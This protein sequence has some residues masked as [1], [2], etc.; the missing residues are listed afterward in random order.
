MIRPATIGL[1]YL[2]PLIGWAQVS[3]P[4]PIA[5]IEQAHRILKSAPISEGDANRIRDFVVGKHAG[6]DLSRGSHR[7][8]LQRKKDGGG[9]VL[10]SLKAPQDAKVSVIA[11]KARRWPMLKLGQSDLWVASEEFADFTSVHY[12][13]DVNGHRLGGGKNNR[14]GF[15]RYQWTPDSLVHPN[16]P[17][18]KLIEMGTHVSKKHFPNSK[19]SWWIYVPQQYNPQQANK[20]KLIVFQDGSGYCRGDGNACVVL[21]NLIDQKKI[22]VAIAVFVNPGTIPTTATGTASRSN[23][24]N[25]YDTCTSRYASFLD[26]ELLPIVRRRFPYSDNPWDHA[27]CGASSG[28]SCAFTAAWHRNDLFRR[29]ISFVGSFCDFR[30]LETYPVYG[31]DNSARFDVADQARQDDFGRWKT[32][33]DYPA[34]IRKTD[35]RR[36]M[37]VFLQDGKNDLDNRLGNWFSNNERMASALAYAGYEYRFVAGKGM[38][39]KRHGMAILPEILVWIWQET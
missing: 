6:V 31:S 20:T 33:H 30:P 13:F 14:F 4:P 2:L 1:C 28:G 27:I 32:A 8:L 9:F 10:W 21:D 36:Q 15:E 18:G 39:S 5:S 24:G 25:E 37:K 7:H 11:E 34:L 35:P 16:V 38:H 29:V 17:K 3:E 22:P 26:E 12:R 19:R 23:R